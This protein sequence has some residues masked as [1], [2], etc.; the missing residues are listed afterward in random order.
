MTLLSSS[1]EANE[2]FE[3]FM[4]HNIPTLRSINLYIESGDKCSVLDALIPRSSKRFIVALNLTSV[5]LE[6]QA[7][8]VHKAGKATAAGLWPALDELNV[9]NCRANTGHFENIAGAIRSGRAP[10]L[11]VLNWNAQS[12]IRERRESRRVDAIILS[13]LASGQCPFIERLSFTDNRFCP[14][15]DIDMLGDALRACSTLRVLEMYCSRSQ[16]HELET[17]TSV[18][19]AGH[20]P[21]L[22]RIFARATK[23][24]E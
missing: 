16:G 8:L 17:L 19:E 6:G 21:R 3:K 10:N 12:S 7:T 9:S 14:E 13:A 1:Q 15:H 4:R 20:V 11:R 18:F 22:A 5:K 2:A 24:Y 23:S